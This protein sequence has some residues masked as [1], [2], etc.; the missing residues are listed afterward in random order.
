M[1]GVMY[2]QILWTGRFLCQVLQSLSELLYRSR[3][4][5]R[6]FIRGDPFRHTDDKAEVFQRGP[7]LCSS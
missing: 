3:Y 1:A 7:L 2:D 5:V 4:R 6:K